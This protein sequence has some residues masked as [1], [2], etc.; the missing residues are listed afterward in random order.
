MFLQKKESAPNQLH[1]TNAANRCN[2]RS[3]TFDRG[4]DVLTFVEQSSDEKTKLSTNVL[5]DSTRLLRT[6]D[7]KPRS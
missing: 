1:Q 2:A 7:G 3:L 6:L 4:I 5:H